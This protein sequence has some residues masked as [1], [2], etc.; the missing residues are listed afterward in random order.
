[1]YENNRRKRGKNKSKDIENIKACSIN[2]AGLSENS[3]ILLDKYRYDEDFDLVFVQETLS[4]DN[5]KL[6]LTGMTTFSDNNNAKNR[7]VALYV[8]NEHSSSEIREISTITDKIDAVWVLTVIGGKRYIVGNVYAKNNYKNAISEVLAMLNKAES[9]C[10]KLKALGVILCGDLNARHTFWKDSVDGQ[11]GKDLLNN[12]KFEKFSI[13]NPETPTF[14]CK[15]GSSFIDLC[16]ISN[17]LT[18]KVQSCTTNDDVYLCS[19]APDRGHVPVVIEISSNKVSVKDNIIQKMDIN[20]INW[21]KWANDLNTE[22]S[23]K[24]DTINNTEDPV[25]LWEILEKTVSKITSSNA[26]MKKLSRHSKPFWTPM[27][28]ELCDK[29]RKARKAYQKR[30]TDDRKEEFRKS[31]EAFDEARKK[32]CENFI[33][34]KTRDLNTSQVRN[35]WKKFNSIFKKKNKSGVDPLL[36]NGSFITEAEEIEEKLFGTFFQCKHMIEGDFDEFFFNTVNNLYEEL[37]TD[38]IETCESQKELNKDV[39]LSEIKKAIKS[40][41]MNKTSL[42]NF[43]MHPKMLLNFSELA[44]EILQKLFNLALQTGKWVW[45]SASVIFLRKSGKKL[46]S[47]P[48]AYRPICITSYV[49]KLL[50]KILAA[51]LNA[52]LINN[53]YYDSKQEGFTAKRNTIRYLN[54]LYIEIQAD[55]ADNQTVIALFADMEKA[56]DSVWKKGLLVK[57]ANLKIKGKISRLIDDFLFSRIVTLNVNG[58]EGD[59]KA[60]EEYGLPQGSALSPVLFKIYMI[61]LLEELD[62]NPSISL[63]KFADDGTVKIKGDTNQK[64]IEL[65]HTVTASLYEWSRRWRMIINCDPNKTEYICFGS[66]DSD[67]LIPNSVS[68]GRKEVKRV[69]KTK[70][71]GLTFDENLSF[72]PHSEDIHRRLLGKWAEICK[73]SN[74]KWG[75]NQRVLTRII[76]TIFISIAQYA[77]HIWLNNKTLEKIDKLWYRI[78]KSTVGAVFNIKQETAEIIIGLP[79]LRL[80]TSI[81]RTKHY[82]KLNILKT[83]CD[84]LQETIASC[85]S[86]ENPPKQLKDSMKEV[87][88]FLQ[89]KKTQYPQDFNMNDHQIISN[90]QFS[91]YCQL[92][93]KSCTY[94]KTSI[95]KY[96]ELIW[97]QISQ[98]QQLMDGELVIAKPQFKPLPIP[99][100]TNRSDEV[101]LMSIFYP[102]NLMN[103]F[104][105]RHT[106]NTE[107]PLCPKCLQKEQ[108]AYHVIMECSDQVEKVKSITS[109]IL[110]E[111]ALLD[112]PN[113]L[114][115][116]SRDPDFIKCALEILQAGQFRR[117][118]EGIIPA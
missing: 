19:G 97:S 82:L 90:N 106:F 100:H 21:A 116:C 88:K 3:R 72:I 86:S 68:I 108:T 44:L 34:N 92:S 18:E 15:D 22:L 51:R 104:I 110:G 38:N 9:L 59:A 113:T 78:L 39:S 28:T 49:G 45:N 48:G 25:K 63:F 61:D 54:R 5:E 11:Y 29:M 71:L 79:P 17:N 6:K 98:N 23:S 62:S 84:S 20:S 95:R 32:E 55:L 42:D 69:E 35:F 14:L 57:M 76:Q 107:S 52:Y 58:Y 80:Q 30:N 53:K 65:L 85:L 101:L 27:L 43:N 118:I 56:F 117:L 64:C 102:N 37:E 50:E 115:N 40:T 70:V 75:F 87:F 94:T 33:I 67:T 26:K 103:S 4:S 36:D 12:I 114:L 99:A 112:H 89:W 93:T 47:T 46:Y 111:D 16:I 91:E 73:Y 8:K 109:K 60:S 83:P 41:D 77:G 24:I 81:N 105:Y 1:M 2:I 31:K 66:D 96:T 10:K 74:S 13:V 7:G